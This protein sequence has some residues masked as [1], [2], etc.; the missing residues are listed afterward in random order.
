MM[1]MDLCSDL[2]PIPQLV[3]CRVLKSYG[4]LWNSTQ[5]SLHGLAAG[6]GPAELFFR[7]KVGKVKL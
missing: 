1:L 4:Y 7:V 5:V 3:L 6:A 2:R